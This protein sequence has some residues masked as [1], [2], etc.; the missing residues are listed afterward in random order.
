M[1]ALQFSPKGIELFFYS[2]LFVDDCFFL[3]PLGFQCVRFL[4]QFGQFPLESFE[5]LLAR[6]IFF[7]FERLPLHFVLHDLALDHVDLCRH[8]VELKLQTRRRFIDKIDCFVRQE[9]VGDIA[10]RKYGGGNERSVGDSHPMV[11]L[12][13]FLQSAQNRDRVFHAWLIYH[14]RLEAT[15]ERGVLLDVFAV[16]IQRGRADRPQFSARKH[17]LQHVRRVD[18]SFGR[19]SPDDRVQFVDEK[20]DLALRIGHFFQER[21]QA[22]FEFATELRAGDHRANVHRDYAFIL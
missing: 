15:L 20:N 12:V 11:H 19:A 14:H 6:R 21:F 3:L 4:F 18:R 13:A 22:V 16:F 5:T 2:A 9:S 8:R 7:F 17:R 1:R 10:M